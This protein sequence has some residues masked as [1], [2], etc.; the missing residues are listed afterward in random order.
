MDIG[1]LVFIL[2]YFIHFIFK[3]LFFLAVLQIPVKECIQYDSEI[4]M[5]T[6]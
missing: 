6:T 1:N 3:Y 5:L 2:F 4:E